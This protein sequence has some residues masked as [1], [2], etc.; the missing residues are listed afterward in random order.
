MI[1]TNL[2]VLNL[3]EYIFELQQGLRNAVLFCYFK[4]MSQILYTLWG[5]QK[6]HPQAS[7]N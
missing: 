1:G 2:I 4:A 7:E 5:L 6:L 3:D